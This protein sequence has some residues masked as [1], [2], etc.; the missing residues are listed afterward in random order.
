MIL[1]QN[2]APLYLEK[3]RLLEGRPT[4]AIC[5]SDWEYDKAWRFGDNLAEEVR[6]GGWAEVVGA[7]GG[8]S[9]MPGLEKAGAD[10]L[11]FT[12]RTTNVIS[13]KVLL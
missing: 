10:L 1:L 13:S 6:V 8:N 5:F 9:C 11:S 3:L 7:G 12:R 4:S 2:F